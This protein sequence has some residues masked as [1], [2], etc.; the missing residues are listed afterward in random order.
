VIPLLPDNKPLP[1]MQFRLKHVL[2]GV[3]AIA[4]S[5][6]F[7][8]AAYIGLTYVET[9]E[10]VARVAWLPHSASNISYYQSYS[11][12]AYEFD[13]PEADFIAWV[14]WEMQPITQPVTVMRYTYIR[15]QR[16][17]PS[18]NA[19]FRELKAY[20]AHRQ[21]EV[22]DGLYYNHRRSNGGGVSVAY[23]RE[24][25]RAYFQSSPR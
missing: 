2:I 15:P 23:D 13:I 24:R 5:L 16:P 7:L 17:K 11:F 18:E 22:A 9:G 6:A 19:D 21:V 14:S 10:N 20:M 4:C 25:G 8:R 1:A 3:T 12:T